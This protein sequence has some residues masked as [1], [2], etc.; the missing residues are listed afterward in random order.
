MT[1]I[2]VTGGTGKI[3]T[4]FA[5]LCAVHPRRPSLRFATRDP[6]GGRAG[7]LRRLA[8]DRFSPVALDE[9]DPAALA[10]AMAGVDAIML[11]SA[12]HSRH[13]RLARQDGGSRQGRRCQLHRQG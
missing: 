4:E 9:D 10:E 6:S 3:G 13:G 11:I 1:T 2:L 8:P 5:Q 12:V 7:L